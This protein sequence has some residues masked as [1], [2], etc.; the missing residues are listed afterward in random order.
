MNSFHDI[1]NSFSDIVI[2]LVITPSPLLISPIY[3]VTSLVHEPISLINL[4]S[5][6]YIVYL[7]WLLCCI[8]ILNSLYSDRRI[9]GL[10]NLT[11]SVSVSAWP[12]LR[13]LFSTLL[14]RFKLFP[15][16]EGEDFSACNR[17]GEK[18]MFINSADVSKI[19]L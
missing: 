4:F 12:C 10:L 2:I 7:V 16:E 19:D 15:G 3:F 14:R 17:H 1:P 9:H 5:D 8:N 18:I 13:F 6:I 11:F